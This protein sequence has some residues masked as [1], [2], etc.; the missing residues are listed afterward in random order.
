M[1]CM[2]CH[3]RPTHIYNP[4]EKAVDGAMQGRTIS[5][6]LPWIKKLAVDSLVR[7]YRDREAAHGGISESLTGLL[8]KQYP[9][10]MG[11]RGAEVEEAIRALSSIYDQNVFPKM[12][13]N[14]TTYASNIGH[15]NWPGCFRCHDG[16]HAT[17]DGKVLSKECTICHTM[18]QRGPLMPLGATAPTS[19]LQ[20]HP[21]PLQ[22]K[23]VDLLCNRCHAAGYRPTMDCAG[24]HK[25]N[26]KA[27]MMSDCTTCHSAPGVKLPLADCK[28]LPPEAR[29]RAQERRPSRGRLH[30]L[31]QAPWV[32]GD[33][34]GRL[35][36][37][38][39]RQ[40]GPQR[41]QCMCGMPRV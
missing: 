31:S 24:C 26:A 14:W 34:S 28:I 8:P 32:E 12:K 30:R 23:H 6:D 35:P 16:K 40:E 5:R 25:L 37:V 7:E 10:V 38:P 29:G 13:V 11:E 20:W 41:A 39:H 17:K 27:P 2:D 3:N 36:G 18:P 19:D 33:L 15:R 22:G 9:Q 21:M 4:P 1:D